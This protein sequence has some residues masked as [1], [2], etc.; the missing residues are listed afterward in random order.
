MSSLSIIPIVEGH[1]EVFAVP[2]LLRRL[3]DRYAPEV[4]IE[5]LPPIRRSRDR[6]LLTGELEKDVELAAE[7]VGPSGI[8][9]VIL[10]T[11]GDCPAELGP[12]VLTRAVS[13][14]PDRTIRVVLAHREYEAWF[15]AAADSLRGKRGL[16][17]DIIAPENPE[18]VQGAK[19]WL[20]HRMSGSR[21]YSETADQV[22]L[23]SV[24]D[25][26]SAR[27]AP[28]FDRFCRLF[29]DLIA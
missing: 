26:D 29:Q 4:S 16:R 17:R 19:E 25:L 6:L 9:L 27:R 21:T 23:T 14:R 8:I 2:A 20:R 1:G 15:L 11:E 24:F 12:Q 18:G 22:A 3:R 28:S 13:T 5:V 10:D 7:K